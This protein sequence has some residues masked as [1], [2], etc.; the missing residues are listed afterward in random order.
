MGSKVW[1]ILAD[2]T[3]IY[4]VPIQCRQHPLLHPHSNLWGGYVLSFPL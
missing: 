1:L 2:D 3:N 4:K